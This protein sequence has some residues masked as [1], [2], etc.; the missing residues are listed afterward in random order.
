MSDTEETRTEQEVTTEDAQEMLYQAHSANQSRTKKTLIA[1]PF[2]I[3]I[4]LPAVSGFLTWYLLNHGWPTIGWYLF[5]AV[6][7]LVAL[8]VI[9][10]LKLNRYWGVRDE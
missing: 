1:L 10:T 4:V 6:P 8:G 3:V 9:A 7:L 5:V 2:V